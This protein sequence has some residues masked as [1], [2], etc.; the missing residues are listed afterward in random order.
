MASQALTTRATQYNQL[1]KES[2]VQIFQ[3]IGKKAQDLKSQLP[4]GRVVIE[5]YIE[6][7]ERQKV[8]QRVAAISL[9][10][11][12]PWIG[13]RKLLVDVSVHKYEEATASALTSTSPASNSSCSLTPKKKTTQEM[14]N[15]RLQNV[16]IFTNVNFLDFQEAHD[17][18]PL[19][20]VAPLA[21]KIFQLL[22]T[23]V[24]PNGIPLPCF[25][26]I[27]QTHVIV[28]TE[29]IH[30]FD[31]NRIEWCTVRNAKQGWGGYQSNTGCGWSNGRDYSASRANPETDRHL[32]DGTDI[33]GLYDEDLHTTIFKKFQEICNVA[34]GKALPSSISP[35][36]IG[37]SAST[38]VLVEELK[39]EG[40]PQVIEIE[41]KK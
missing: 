19:G 2:N 39:L 17:D 29:E 34:K 21:N 38:S 37:T 18:T 36:A 9:E 15:G 12:V 13:D 32:S 10:N 26:D 25:E 6:T 7:Q 3:A 1:A 35:K 4:N 33:W 41:D 28:M 20:P 40:Q 16:D 27:I 30:T 14:Q 8:I 22:K 31:S 5:I 23:K 24:F 11:N